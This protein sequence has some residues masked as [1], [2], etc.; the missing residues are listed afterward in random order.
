M[1]I[2]IIKL[3]ALGDIVHA[4]VV[5]QYIK[6]INAKIEIDWI[7]EENYKDLLESN[8]DINKVHVINIKKAKQKK[9][10]TLL[11][12][13]IK[14]T[15]NL[16]YYDCVIDMQGLIKS[17]LIARLIPSKLT[18]GFDRL[19]AREG[20]AS[21]FYN[22]T[23]NYSY[24]KNI[25]MRNLA[26]TKFALKDFDFHSDIQN[27]IPFLFSSKKYSFGEICKVKDNILL[28]PG[29]S[30]QAKCYPIDKFIELIN[31]IDANFLII[32]GDEAEK[33]LAK[34]IFNSSPKVN[35]MEKLSL[36]SLKS[37]ISQVDLVIGSDTGPT[38]MA[39]ALNV[40][41][42]SLFGP[43]PGQRNTLITNIN[44]IIESETS[45]NPNKINKSDY[46]IKNIKVSDV[47]EIAKDL[48]K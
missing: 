46:S 42:I 6:N 12:K 17:A 9:S 4:M 33:K 21:I 43:T 31:K 25:I 48:L 3:S 24:S 38:H 15:Q 47:A 22:Q 45:V 16:G 32:W 11:Y 35:I 7:V 34:Q 19:S 28:I 1:K 18:I 29:A 30:F 27:K 2:A 41:S 5:L 37:L 13:E 14:K 39:W 40:P 8:L 10:F 36:D 23:F 26:L 20:L 44:K